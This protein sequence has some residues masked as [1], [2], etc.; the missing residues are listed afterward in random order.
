VAAAYIGERSAPNISQL[1]AL[2]HRQTQ[3]NHFLEISDDAPNALEQSSFAFD[4]NLAD[5]REAKIGNGDKRIR[6]N[7]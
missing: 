4:I 5:C 1:R 7:L 3:T 6:P 2:D